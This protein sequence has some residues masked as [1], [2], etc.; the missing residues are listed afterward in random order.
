VL[1]IRLEMKNFL[2]YRSP[3]PI[4]FEGIHLAC[5]SGDNGAGKSSLLDAITWALWGKARAKRDEELIHLGQNEMLVLLEFEQNGT[6][7][8]VKRA[9]SRSRTA[10]TLA[11]FSTDPDGNLIEL[12]AGSIKAT[13]ALIDSTINLDYDTF[14]HSAFLR[15]GNADAFTL[16]T[17]RERKQILA[18]ILGLSRWEAYEARAK[19]MIEAVAG[20]IAIAEGQ[21]R[22]IDAMVSR[23][24]DIKRQL[25]SAQTLLI[26]AVERARAAQIAY[27]ELRDA[28]TNRR[29]AEDNLLEARHRLRMIETRLTSAAKN[30]QIKRGRVD[31]YAALLARRDEIETGYHAL[32]AARDLDQALGEKLIALKRLDDRRAELD[33]EIDAARA[34]IDGERKAA[35]ARVD[36]LRRS[37]AGGDAGALEAIQGEIAALRTREGARAPLQKQLDTHRDEHSHLS[38]ENKALKAEMNKLNDRRNRLETVEGALCPF[39]GQPLDADHRASLIADITAEGTPMGDLYRTN[40]NR[41]RALDTLIAEHQE[42]ITQVALAIQ[43]LADLQARAGKLA[44]RLDAAREAE[45]GLQEESARLAGLDT[46]LHSADYA[47]A[48]RAER[49]SLDATRAELGYDDASHQGARQDLRAYNE[50]DVR[51]HQLQNAQTA[52]AAAIADLDDA[53]SAVS[54]QKALYDSEGA[55][56]AA[57]EEAIAALSAL[58]NEAQRRF[59]EMKLRQDEEAAARENVVVFNQ[60]LGAIARGRLRRVDLTDR[61]AG[62]RERRAL[63]DE[64]RLAF[65]KNGIPAMII[66][67]ALPELEEAANRLLGRMSEGQ[68]TIA[69][70]TQR[71]KVTGGVAE[72][73]DILIADGLGTRA[74]E[75]Y[76]GGEAFRINFALR[77]ALSQMLARRAGAQ[78][79]T[80]FIDEGF[81]TQDE[82]GRAKLVEAIT[83]IQDEFDLI[84]V[85]THIDDLRDAFP[86]HIEIK[87]TEDGSQI[88]LR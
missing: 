26:E 39:C 85:I 4:Y 63:Y 80:L 86:V 18:D 77:V 72:T 12:D 33:R 66:D 74:Y 56:V 83:A 59:E 73:L 24:P 41:V 52:Q 5:L 48:E 75:M 36:G 38:A 14:T 79:R 13:Q 9:R 53:E 3:A 47:H 76:S 2:A 11:F 67:A 84:L 31:E 88:T 51:Y 27:D 28:A 78:L 40:G 29:H 57:L 44:E 68:M 55:A 65:G 16:K 34:A 58:A 62:E 21:I 10:G 81:G 7:Y 1:P 20:E 54:E 17:A 69:I 42:A 64:L 35:S 22:E 25:A 82:A 50:Y 87:K 37:A 60:E 43:P 45:A 8:Q 61:I 32:Q 46:L 23:E 71:E 15:Q 19:A 70:T 6:R 30:A 49:D